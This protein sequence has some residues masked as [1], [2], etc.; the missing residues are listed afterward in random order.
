MKR[1][2]AILLTLALLLCACGTKPMEES[3]SATPAPAESTAP[4]D[5][6]VPPYYSVEFLEPG[7]AFAQARTYLWHEGRFLCTKTMGANDDYARSLYWAEPYSDDAQELP[8]T[9][10]GNETIS[11]YGIGG[12]GNIYMIISD[13][14]EDAYTSP[15]G[16][17][18]DGYRSSRLLC[19]DA[20]GQVLWETPLDQAGT[21]HYVEI[22]ADPAGQV[23]VIHYE[24]D[25]DVSF[26]DYTLDRMDASGI[27]ATM[28]ATDCLQDQS[29][30][31][32]GF[33]TAQDGTPLVT[34]QINEW[35]QVYA[36][37][38]DSLTLSGPYFEHTSDM[39]WPNLSSGSYADFYVLDDNTGLTAY[40]LDG[41]SH[42]YFKLT[43]LPATVPESASLAAVPE[44]NV[45]LF[46]LYANNSRYFVQV[47]GL[48]EEP[49]ESEKI[50][51]TIGTT[52]QYI[53]GNRLSDLVVTF[54]IL[55]PEYELV[56][57]DYF[58]DDAL[59]NSD[60]QREQLNMDI[61]NGEGPDILV[62]DQY[63]FPCSTY[64]GNGFLT[65][66]YPLME[67]DPEFQSANYYKNLWSVYE[68]QGRLYG[69]TTCFEIETMCTNSD[70]VDVPE[71]WTPTECR[72]IAASSDIPLMEG[73]AANLS[74]LDWYAAQY[75]L[76]DGLSDYIDGDTCDF[77]SGEFAALLELL[78]ADYPVFES[79]T[80]EDS[81]LLKNG[82]ILAEDVS[83][84][85]ASM[86]LS[87]KWEYGDSW[88]ITGYP[89]PTRSR[90]HI[91]PLGA[92]GISQQTQ[93]PDACWAFLKMALE[94]SDREL[95]QSGIG[96]SVNRDVLAET[97]HR[98]TLPAD[99]PN[100][101][102]EQYSYGINNETVEVE[103]EP[104][105]QAEAD[106]L[107][108][109]IETATCAMVD[110]ETIAIVQE[111]AA[112]FFSGD[113]TAQQVAEIIQNRVQLHLWE[114]G[115]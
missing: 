92:L 1:I 8:L 12:D 83:L 42:S 109:L 31:F 2:T 18:V 102:V 36:V 68:N 73:L 56:L 62:L 85:H 103:L 35:P 105:T 37:D 94:S 57:K 100:T 14:V 45:W 4:E 97:M 51:L 95:S 82:K 107:L 11:C 63:G 110:A 75:L 87:K 29:A 27:N 23:F 30:I 7:A 112:A 65:D 47:T 108:H 33:L 13:V 19:L 76:G 26:S 79:E 22:A 71:G 115:G 9:L 28:Q 88:V 111:E 98:L 54:N 40:T 10:S 113:K 15:I 46:V 78:A 89:T 101:L 81:L 60:A 34:V 72:E 67:A 21:T 20:A 90:I 61:L 16:F 64:A 104:L 41:Q 43:D 93:H 58:Q 24:F 69:L 91:L 17:A 99:D 70:Y 25:P 53:G 5:V 38:M 6:Q 52:G 39:M 106:A 49:P 96:F 3:A 114:Q 48:W 74:Y 50:P 66:L 80:V 77:S 44:E 59:L 86:V 55:H 32:T 84:F